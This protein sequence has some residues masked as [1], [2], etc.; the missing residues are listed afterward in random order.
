MKRCILPISLVLAA[1]VIPVR[2]DDPP[3][4]LSPAQQVCLDHYLVKKKGIYGDCGLVLSQCLENHPDPYTAED[5]QACEQLMN[6]CIE[7]RLQQAIAD[8]VTCL[9][10][11]PWEATYKASLIVKVMYDPQFLAED[12]Q[13]APGML[14]DDPPS[15]GGDPV[16]ECF[17]TYDQDLHEGYILCHDQFIDCRR[18]GGYLWDCEDELHDCLE[19]R[20]YMEGLQLYNCIEQAWNDGP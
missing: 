13:V 2:A 4:S 3:P 6:A 14:R 15:L 20:R 11:I 17:N 7:P 18:Y 19:L 9:L 8:L 10:D 5:F 16:E 12:E 1:L